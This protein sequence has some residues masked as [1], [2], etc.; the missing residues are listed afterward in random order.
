M[1]PMLKRRIGK[2]SQIT[3]TPYDNWLSI[4]IVKLGFRR[5]LDLPNCQNQGFVFKVHAYYSKF[6]SFQVSFLGKIKQKE[7]VVVSP[8]AYL[9]RSRQFMS[10]NIQLTM[11]SSPVAKAFEPALNTRKFFVPYLFVHQK[12]AQRNAEVI[13]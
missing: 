13:E 12:K 2:R 11:T 1:I 8:S 9:I 3:L 10:K 7:K 4:A 6:L 5:I